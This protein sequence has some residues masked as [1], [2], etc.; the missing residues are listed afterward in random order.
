MNSDK[1][2]DAR[3]KGCP[4]LMIELNKAINGMDP[5]QVLEFLCNDQMS[6]RDIPLWCTRT[7]NDMLERSPG[8]DGVYRYLIRKGPGRPKV[9]LKRDFSRY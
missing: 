7:G 8:G 4:M 6:Y 3:G 2:H 5:G 1:S 9:P